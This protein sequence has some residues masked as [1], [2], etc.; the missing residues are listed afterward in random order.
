MLSQSQLPTTTNLSGYLRLWAVR[1]VDRIGQRLHRWGV[2]PDVLTVLG[3]AVTALASVLVAQGAFV[4]AALV[5]IVGMPLDVL[6]GAVARAMRRSSLF[7]GILD[8]TVDRYADLFVLLA[9]AYYCAQQGLTTDLLLIFASV[10][11][12]IQV[13]YV[14]AR[15]GAAGLPCAGG[16]F[17]RFER[18]VVVLATLLTGWLTLGMAILAVGS[19]VTA[20]HRLWSVYR[21]ASAK[22]ED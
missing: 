19:N 7:G 11:G 18:S 13:S 5:L 15:A 22:H 16:L 20:L 10:I 8:S 6:D 14:R 17:S 3:L 4:P 12:S 1:F 2:H 9:L 21:F